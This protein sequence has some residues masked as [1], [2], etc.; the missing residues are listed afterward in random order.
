[1]A[2][3]IAI[4]NVEMEQ[5]KLETYLIKRARVDERVSKTEEM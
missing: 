5:E 4:G 1:M 3:E 2:I